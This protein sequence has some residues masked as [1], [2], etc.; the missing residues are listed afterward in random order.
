MLIP[1][2]IQQ[3]HLDYDCL[4]HLRMLRELHTHQQSAVRCAFDTKVLRRSELPRHQIQGNRV[5]VVVDPLPLRLEARIV[6]C[7][8]ELSA[9]TNICQHKRT[10]AFQPQLAH[11]SV[12]AR[13]IRNLE[14]PIGR[15]QSWPAAVHFDVD[16]MDHEVWHLCSVLRCRL[17]LLYHVV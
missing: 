4:P 3:R 17:K 13:R 8:S 7:R 15:Q 16:A 11:Y 2:H 1:Q 14:P 10:A 12:V 9:T 5:E 6:P